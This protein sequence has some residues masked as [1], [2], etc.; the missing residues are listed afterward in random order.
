MKR[1][2]LATGLLAGSIVAAAVP[3]T[4][5]AAATAWKPPPVGHVFVINLENEDAASTFGAGSPAPYLSK[6]LRSKGNLLTNYYGIGH[7]SLDN[8]QAQISGQGPNPQT[9]ADCQIF[10]DFVRLPVPGPNGQAIGQGCVFPSAVKTIADQL[11]A[12]HKTWRGYMEDMGNTPSRESR[13][14]GHPAIGSQD[15]TQSATSGDQYAARHNPF[16]YFH[17]LLDSGSCAKNDV[18][19]TALTKD[20]SSVGTTRNLSYITPNL[21]N[22]GHDS[23]C[24][25]GKPGGLASA[26]AWLKI[27]VPR[28]LASPAF[29]KDG[30][31]VVTFDESGGPNSD[32]TAC[33]GE[34]AVNTPLAGI[35]G[36]GGG[37]VGAVLV[38]RWIKPGSTTTQPYNHYS[39][40]ASIE[41]AMHLPLLGYAGKA[42]LPHFGKDV[43]TAG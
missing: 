30:L 43:Y 35:T 40:L 17:S 9:Q 12:T 42:G 41:D 36:T 31:L 5:T 1:A 2:L 6:T 26:D 11:T 33:C 16:V 22:D 34:T 4:G 29:K 39:L 32:S 15:K 21:C 7:N 13:T 27:W 38:S 3:A 28:I 14:C 23:P 19:L 25:N 37:R 10:T 20:L 18:P 24:A 8:Y